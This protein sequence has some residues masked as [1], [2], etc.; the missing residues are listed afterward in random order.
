MGVL[1]PVHQS[2]DLGVG[3]FCISQAGHCEDLKSKTLVIVIG[4][5]QVSHQRCSELP[6]SRFAPVEENAIYFCET[7]HEPPDISR[8]FG[9][10]WMIIPYL[11]P[12]VLRAR[13]HHCSA[14]DSFLPNGLPTVDVNRLTAI[15]PETD[16][17]N[18]CLIMQVEV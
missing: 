4:T 13:Y 11:I 7:A 8:S 17:N 1:T 16:A 18:Y 2:L 14:Y 9:L 15:G 5:T 12:E 10:I 6:A 3:F